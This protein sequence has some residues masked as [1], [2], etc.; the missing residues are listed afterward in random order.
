MFIQ[1]IWVPAGYAGS[2]NQLELRVSGFD[3]IIELGESAVV[4]P[5]SIKEI[6][7]PDLDILEFK[8]LGMTV[9]SA[10]SAP[11]GIGSAGYILDFVQGILD[12]RGEIGRASCRER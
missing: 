12:V 11:I 9:G 5:G 10:L 7:V 8:R 1:H 2:R 3:G 6:F 4:T